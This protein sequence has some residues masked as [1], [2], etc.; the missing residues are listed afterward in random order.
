MQTA[1]SLYVPDLPLLSSGSG[2]R[3]GA[4]QFQTGLSSEPPM[5]AQKN[6]NKAEKIGTN[7]N[8]AY[9]S[10]TCDYECEE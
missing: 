10:L 1:L 7:R 4:K 5:K 8:K 6:E 3:W 9:E 2:G